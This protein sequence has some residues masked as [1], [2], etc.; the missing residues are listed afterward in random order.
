MAKVE[1]QYYALPHCGTKLSGIHGE[2]LRQWRRT[3]QRRSQRSKTHWS[4]LTKKDWFKLPTPRILH[5][6][7]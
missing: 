2:V 3:L 4:Y 6:T 5:P 1:Y 7:V